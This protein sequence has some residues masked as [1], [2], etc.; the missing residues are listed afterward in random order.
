[1]SVNAMISPLLQVAGVVLEEKQTLG[2]R[3]TLARIPPIPP[4]SAILW[5]SVR[6]RERGKEEDNVPS[7][8]SL[9]LPLHL[10]CDGHSAVPGS[11]RVTSRSSVDA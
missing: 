9:L 2:V 3:R 10:T 5:H 8:A 6:A 11:P 4:P 7:A 1:M